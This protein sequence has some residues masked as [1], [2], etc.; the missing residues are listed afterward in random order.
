M[1]GP[2][3]TSSAPSGS[4]ASAT[5]RVVIDASVAVKAAVVEAGFQQLISWELVAPTLMWS[6]ACA[7]ISQLRW[8]GELTDMEAEQAVVRLVVAPVTPH[9]SADLITEATQIARRLGWAKTYDAEYL[10]LA[11]LLGIALLTIDARLRSSA[12]AVVRIIGP[13]D[14]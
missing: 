7:A 5:D 9:P 14:P 8:R 1:A 11:S 12:S 6:E 2:P 10:A 3:Q 13:T 4:P